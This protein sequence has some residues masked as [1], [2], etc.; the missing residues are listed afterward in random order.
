M[1][2]RAASRGLRSA[3]P[4]RSWRSPFASVGTTSVR[5]VHEEQK[6]TTRY[7][8]SRFLSASSRRPFAEPGRPGPGRPGKQQP[9]PPRGNAA[10]LLAAGLIAATFGWAGWMY[11]QKTGPFKLVKT[12]EELAA[13]AEYAAKKLEF[14][15]SKDPHRAKVTDRVYFDISINGKPKGRI[16]LGLFGETAPKTVANFLALTRSEVDSPNN[17]GSKLSYKAT[18]FHRIIPKFMIQGGD[19]TNGDG[20]GGHSIYGPSFPDENF[21]L[22]HVRPGVLSMA[23]AGPNTNSSQFFITTTQ[24]PWLDDR[25]VIFGRVTD[26]YRLVNQIERL[27]SKSGKPFRSVEIAACGVLSE[28]EY[29]AWV[30]KQAQLR[31]QREEDAANN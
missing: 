10:N 14:Q 3:P 19:V 8:Q 31:K 2:L 23:N 28:Q 26:G 11:K 13:D 18:K 4:L 5:V 24:C 20:T 1:M 9:P 27:G 29:S 30:E 17:P 15:L 7:V 25:H 12:P 22:W 6:E 16:V 21:D